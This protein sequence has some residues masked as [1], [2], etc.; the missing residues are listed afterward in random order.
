MPGSLLGGLRIG[1]L[2]EALDGIS[3]HRLLDR[4]IRG[5]AWIGVVAFALIGIVAMQLW[6][7]K[8]GVGIGRALEHEALLQREN[9]ALSIQDTRLS[10]GERVE[11]LAAARGM[12]VA[13]PGSVRF[14]ATRGALDARLAAAALAKSAQVHAVATG[15]STAEGEGAATPAAEASEGAAAGSGEASAPGAASEG[16]SSAEGSGETTGSASSA[17]PA[18]EASGNTEVSGSGEASGSSEESTAGG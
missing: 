17:A 9:A 15:E 5:R 3:R 11:A 7:V 14:D 12:V 18:A 1:G 4:L 6:I 13:A 8:L 16:G 10:D 2:L